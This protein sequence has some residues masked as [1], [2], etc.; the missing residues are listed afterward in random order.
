MSA[1]NI[2]DYIDEIEEDEEFWERVFR[3]SGTSLSSWEQNKAITYYVCGRY[4]IDPHDEH[5]NELRPA[6]LVAK[7]TD[8]SGASI[9]STVRAVW[10]G[11]PEPVRMPAQS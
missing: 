4:G 9:R 8:A 5:G 10:G 3:D 6:E 1:K 2:D 11:W 7:I